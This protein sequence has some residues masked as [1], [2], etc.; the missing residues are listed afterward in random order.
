MPKRPHL[1]A[2]VEAVAQKW[3]EVGADVTVISPFP[4]WT[5]QTGN[6]VLRAPE[7]AEPG[8][9]RLI[10]PGYLSF[11]NVQLGGVSTRRWTQ[12][13]FERALRRGARRAQR[14]F[15][16]PDVVY[17]HF[18]FPGGAAALQLAREHDV[19]VVV[20]LGESGDLLDD[21][22][23]VFGRERIRETL[24][25]FDGVL[26]VSRGTA[27]RCRTQWGLDPA[28]ARVIR[29]AVDPKRFHPRDRRAMR[30]KLG[31]PAD[32]PIVVFV[33]IF[34]ER[35]GPLR[36][37][38]ALRRVPEARAIFVGDGPERLEG[39]QVLHA[40]SLPHERVPEF[41]CAADLF[42]LPTRTEGS[43]NAVIEAMACGLPV[44][45]SDIPA[46]REVVTDACAKLVDPLDV[47]ALGKAMA[48][49]LGSPD[50]RRA[51][52]EAA[53]AH[54]KGF[55][56]DERSRRILDWLEETR[57]TRRTTRG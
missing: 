30:E 32:V 4:Y 12:A 54:A 57:T 25:A 18:L 19:P 53:H 44:L 47:E 16:K 33:G 51:M 48:E 46:V 14:S 3:S 5:P 6:V 29:N 41:L 52:G 40:G 31:L 39:G 11:S 38:E 43:P 17:A 10:R 23:R 8:A 27:D 37:L 7:P 13:A 26:C 2:F 42:V 1:A 49:L 34:V 15:G 9:P 50:R 24:A 56:L 36:V 35:K 28:R 20:A 21:H 45:S 22:E 55:S